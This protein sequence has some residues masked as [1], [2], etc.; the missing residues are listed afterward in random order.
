MGTVRLLVCYSKNNRR[1]CVQPRAD[2]V[3][4]N[5]VAEVWRGGGLFL[6]DELD[7]GGVEIVSDILVALLLQD[8]VVC[9]GW[10][11]VKS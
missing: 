6:E 9:S 11:F 5:F 1:K 8:Q 7:E 3:W 4:I 2:K 10:M